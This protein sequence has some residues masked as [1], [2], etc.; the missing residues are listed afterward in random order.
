M[1][2]GCEKIKVDGKWFEQDSYS[3]YDEMVR[4]H[5][6]NR[7]YC[8]QCVKLYEQQAVIMRRK[9]ITN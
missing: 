6:I 9:A 8:P 7:D 2:S 5:N 1:C 4:T 3:D